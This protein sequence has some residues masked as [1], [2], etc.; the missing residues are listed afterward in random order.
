MKLIT[1]WLLEN[2]YLS[3]TN[4]YGTTFTRLL[5]CNIDQVS[6]LNEK[7]IVTGIIKYPACEQGWPRDLD[8]FAFSDKEILKKIQDKECYFI[9][10]ASAEGHN[11]FWWNWFEILYRNCKTYE[12]DP[13]QIIFISSNLKDEENLRCYCIDNNQ[14]PIHLISLPFFEHNFSLDNDLIA[15]LEKVKFSTKTN[16]SGKYFS[17]LSRVKRSHRFIAQ[18]LLYH[19]DLQPHALLS[20]DKL[21]KDDL[22]FFKILF[23]KN[24]Y[25]N[26][27]QVN[28]WNKKILP[29]IVD[30]K[31][32][33]I[34]WAIIGDYKHI[35]HQ[36]LFQLVNETLVDNFDNTS[37]FYS[38]KTF[39]PISCFQPFIIFGQKGCNH[40][41]KELGYQ[42]YDD[43]FDL[44]FD[45]EDDFIDR[46]M[47]ILDVLKDTC[48]K[49]QSMSLDK[50]IE[51]KFKNQEILLYNYNNMKNRDISKQKIKHFI[52]KLE[53]T[54][55]ESN[56]SI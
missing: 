45:Y 38:E 2:L 9:F 37:M 5:N 55:K 36:T 14:K 19:H 54:I 46:F 40:Y 29:L 16:Y 34:N 26:L 52:T 11:P 28:R 8:L 53:N 18:F 15:E 51:W 39:R 21:T 22:D 4:V 24:P 3:D 13:S 6:S 12:I 31:N 50:Q 48:K 44:S 43:W 20:Q 7:S 17:S 35:H 33:D 1:N 10:D 56:R 23:S 32:F 49:L 42:T 27:K 41:L 47:K 30:Y 25:Y